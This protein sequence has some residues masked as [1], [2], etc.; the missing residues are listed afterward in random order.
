MQTPKEVTYPYALYALDITLKCII[1]MSWAQQ[2]NLISHATRKAHNWKS[3]NL[4]L[5]QMRSFPRHIPAHIYIY[6]LASISSFL[7][8]HLLFREISAHSPSHFC[9]S[10]LS[11]PSPSMPSTRGYGK[12]SS[13]SCSCHSPSSWP[14]AIPAIALLHV[15]EHWAM[16]GSESF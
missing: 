7:S 16:D 11:P 12:A 1:K 4:P 9:C 3:L 10:A 8:H 5:L 14:P 2:Y 15:P 13:R 6:I